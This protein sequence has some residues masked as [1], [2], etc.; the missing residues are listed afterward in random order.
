MH[1]GASTGSFYLG[2]YQAGVR[3]SDNSIKVMTPFAKMSKYLIICK[4][5]QGYLFIF[6]VNAMNC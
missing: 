3:I 2:K 6:F 1:S 4:L 5:L